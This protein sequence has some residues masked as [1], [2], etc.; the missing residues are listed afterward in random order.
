MLEVLVQALRGAVERVV[1]DLDEAAR[2]RRP[3]HLDGG[4]ADRLRDGLLA[5]AEVEHAAVVV[6]QDHHRRHARVVELRDGAR[7]RVARE[8][9]VGAADPDVAQ[10]DVE[11][12]VLL[13]HVIVDDRDG[14]LLVQ[15]A[16]REHQ[17]AGAVLVVGAGVRRAVLRRVIH[18]HRQVLVA[19][20]ARHGRVECADVLHD[21]VVAGLEENACDARVFGVLHGHVRQT[22]LALQFRLLDDVASARQLARRLNAVEGAAL[23]AAVH[24]LHL[25]HLL[26]RLHVDVRVLAAQLSQD[27]DEVLPV[28]LELSHLRVLAVQPLEGDLVDVVRLVVHLYAALRHHHRLAAAR[29]VAL[30]QELVDED[31]AVGDVGRHDGGGEEEEREHALPHLDDAARE[32]GDDEVHPQVG[33]HA[34]RRRDEEHA[35]VLDA[36]DLVVR[37][38]EDADA[39][40]DEQVEGGAADDRTRAEVALLEAV[41]DDLDDG[42]HDF[43]RRRAERHQRQVRHSLVPDA[44]AHDGR[45]AIRSAHRHFLLLRRDHLDGGHEAVGDDGHAEEEEGHRGE[46]DDGPRHLVADT[47]VRVRLPH[48]HDDPRHAAFGRTARPRVHRRRVVAGV[49]HADTTDDEEEGDMQRAPPPPPAPG[50]RYPVACRRH[51]WRLSVFHSTPLRTN[52]RTRRLYPLTITPHLGSAQLSAARLGVAG[53]CGCSGRAFRH[54]ARAEPPCLLGG[55]ICA[56]EA[57]RCDARCEGAVGKTNLNIPGA[58]PAIDAAP[59]TD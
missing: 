54:A 20:P 14:D 43:G 13:E 19:A 24:R 27:L 48:G 56:S 8:H 9:T 37:D 30:A 46:V 17:R 25:R 58:V 12:L 11:V 39:D 50:C 31:L 29:P 57:L 40:D 6:V 36:P 33:E 16:G 18:V 42:Q 49:R 41:A 26:Q 15:L 10:P 38:A 28:A 55:V 22:R 47:Q 45:L 59:P 52:V 2:A 4:L 34:P 53:D 32:H 23:R 5:L 44:H 1:A 35:Q 21:R 7:V 51:R 3:T